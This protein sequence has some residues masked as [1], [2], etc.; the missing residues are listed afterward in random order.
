MSAKVQ[1]LSNHINGRAVAPA[2]DRWLDVFEPATGQ[3]YAR[4]PA[5]DAADVEAAVAAARQAFPGWSTL[6]A[7]QR[8]RWL[9]KLAGA[10]EA[11][12]EEFAQ[13]ES[14]DGGRTRSL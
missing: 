12:I 11:R 14:R 4:C 5:S 10:L 13:A 8:A 9:E 7:S 1:L 6:P 3:V 2:N